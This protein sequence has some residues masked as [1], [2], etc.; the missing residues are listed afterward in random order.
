[1][2]ALAQLCLSSVKQAKSHNH[3]CS[4]LSSC[5]ALGSSIND[6][7]LIFCENGFLKSLL[8]ILAVSFID[9]IYLK[10][11]NLILHTICCAAFFIFY[12]LFHSVLSVLPFYIFKIHRYLSNLTDQVNSNSVFLLVSLF[13]HCFHFY[14]SLSFSTDDH[15][16]LH[17]YE[18]TITGCEESFSDTMGC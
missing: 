14:L 17:S 11:K 16:H 12:D 2:T 13:F 7:S 10:F 5:L 18:D 9:F 6:L 15:L 1:M 4:A 8:Q 3:L